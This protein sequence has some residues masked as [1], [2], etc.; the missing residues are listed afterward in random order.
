MPSVCW[1]NIAITLI[2][3]Q[4][5]IVSVIAFS[6][7]AVTQ[8]EHLESGRE[9]EAPCWSWE[10]VGQPLRPF[11]SIS[12]RTI[13]C[14][15]A[16]ALA[17]TA[18]PGD[19]V[20]PRKASG[21]FL[22]LM[23]LVSGAFAA[24][25]KAHKPWHVGPKLLYSFKNG[26]DGGAIF[27]GVARDRWGNLYGETEID[28]HDHGYGTLFRLAP[29]KEGYSFHILAHFSEPRGTYCETT[30]AVDDA[31]NVFG[32]C[33]LGGGG[34]GT[35]W[36]YSRRGQ[37]TVLHSFTGPGDGMM[38]DDIVLIG[39]DEI[40]GTTAEFGSGSSGTF[41]KYSR[42]RHTFTLLHS[43]ASGA[44]GGSPGGPTID[45]KGILWGITVY[46]PNCY[47]CGKGTVWNYDPS[48]GTFTTVLDFSSTGISTPQNN[49]IVDERGNLFGT[50]FPIDGS[51]LGMIYELE[52]DNNYAPIILYT[53]TDQQNGW[54]PGQLSFDERGNLIGTTYL[55][56]Q[57][58]QGTT[59]V[60]VHKDRGWKEIVLHSFDG[61]DGSSPLDGVV[62]DNHRRWFGT[63]V[64]G[65]KYGQ[66]EVFEM[67]S[68]P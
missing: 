66:G 48:S 11:K 4:P 61:S 42:R 13:I 16:R 23:V 21:I 2:G 25:A 30:P 17:F 7:K 55:G 64:Y 14:P 28:D 50:A 38:P 9:P 39:S 51:N 24:T 37:F 20:M 44:D 62:T 49:F 45:H 15:D 56:G 18:S 60:L 40:Y 47:D 68:I 53:F 32:V 59:Y 34:Y 57:F 46:G 67:P 54:G 41:W 29:H 1:R 36:E 6:W 5:G 10:S 8:T 63:T 26:E 52:A 33:T 43:F 19:T 27:G 31:G 22:S 65:G 3:T 58:N 35:L 12:P